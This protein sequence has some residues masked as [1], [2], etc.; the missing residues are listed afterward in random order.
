MTTN[1]SALRAHRTRAQNNGETAKVAQYDRRIRAVKKGRPDPKASHKKP[2]GPG[3]RL[4]GL[5]ARRTTVQ[6]KQPK[7]SR[8]IGLY[9][10]Q[11]RDELSKRPT[12]DDG[13]RTAKEAKAEVKRTRRG[14]RMNA[15]GRNVGGRK[16]AA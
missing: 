10:A 12:V 9:N 4:A 6:R 7:N 15:K 11:I 1:I 14:Q 8:L 13:P 2:A 5:K 3:R 16:R